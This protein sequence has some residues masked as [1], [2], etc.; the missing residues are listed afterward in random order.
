METTAKGLWE[1]LEKMYMGKN[2]TNKLWPKKQLYNL[3]MSEEGD[4]VSHIQRFNQVYS[5]LM[6]MDVKI[7]EDRTLL[8]LCS[9]P[10]V[11]DG[12]ITTL[13]YDKKSLEY[14]EVV[15]ALR[16]NEQWEKT[17]KGG[18]IVDTCCS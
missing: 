7:E 9:F 14:E 1:K 3:R 13:V 12:L 11:Y 18:S 17:C 16:S 4:L 10:S 2:M 6:N 8:L 5:D 15:G